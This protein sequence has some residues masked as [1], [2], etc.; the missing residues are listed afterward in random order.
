M[1]DGFHL[2]ALYVYG[3]LAISSSRIPVTEV[4]GGEKG[5]LPNRNAE[6]LPLVGHY[7]EESQPQGHLMRVCVCV[8]TD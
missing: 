3:H 6:E 1:N 4:V 2:A 5:T 7:H 8:L